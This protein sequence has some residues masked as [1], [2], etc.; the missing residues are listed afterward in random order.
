LRVLLDPA[1]IDEGYEEAMRGRRRQSRLLGNLGHAERFSDLRQQ[2]D[3]AQRSLYRP[4]RINHS[5]LRF[6]AQ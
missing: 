6:L 3:D 4:D 1:F 5:Q 2:A